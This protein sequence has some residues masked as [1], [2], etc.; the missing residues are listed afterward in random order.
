MEVEGH[1]G[2]LVRGVKAFVRGEARESTVADRGV[3]DGDHHGGRVMAAEAVHE[4]EKHIPAPK[5]VVLY[6][7]EG[8]RGHLGLQ[9]CSGWG[10]VMAVVILATSEYTKANRYG[11]ENCV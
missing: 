3:L 6:N 2:S 4:G 7:R 11:S 8:N 1:S 5:A 9:G 10:G